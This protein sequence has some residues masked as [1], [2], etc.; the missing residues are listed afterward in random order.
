[1][2]IR[3]V[4][5]INDVC[6]VVLSKPQGITKSEPAGTI[7][8]SG[9]PTSLT[10]SSYASPTLDLDFAK[11]QSVDS[12]ITFSRSTTAS[13]YD[14]NGFLRFAAVNQPRIQFDPDTKECLGLLMENVST[15]II[16]ASEWQFGA[17]NGF[18]NLDPDNTFDPSDVTV[19]TNESGTVRSLI[20]STTAS[21]IRYAL[22]A[23]THIGTEICAFSAFFKQVTNNQVFP[24]LVIDNTVG[25]GVFAR[26]NLVN[27]T[28][29]QAQITGT[30]VLIASGIEKLPGGWSRCWVIGRSPATASGRLAISIVGG[31]STNG[32]DPPWTPTAVGDGVRV[33]GIQYEQ[34][35]PFNR[36]RP[37][38]YIRTQSGAI[39]KF[40]D[41]ASITGTNFS[42]WYNQ[43]QG[44][45]LV[46][47]Y[48]R[49]AGNY[50]E[51]NMIFR[52]SDGTLNNFIDLSGVT[53]TNTIRFQGTTAAGNSTFQTANAQQGF[54][55]AVGTYLFNRGDLVSNGTRTTAVDTLYTPPTALIGV[56]IGHF[57]GSFQL[58]DCI[59]RLVYYPISIDPNV[60]LGM[61]VPRNF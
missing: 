15:N 61:S 60:T 17:S 49:Y 37:S 54:N 57:G 13:Y 40:A 18:T 46:D 4:N 24:C 22:A 48:K 25:S 39:T 55:R 11:T 43:S 21:S 52:F 29:E 32:Y 27:G 59:A 5:Y 51:T 44:T 28:V 2:T 9:T 45:I 33:W 56:D 6:R 12:R 7:R 42:R 53:G 16:N 36:L 14:S 8:I 1:M 26:F 41:S 20:A 38:S 23:K 30:G 31:N 35:L 58:N 50:P 34:G 3:D 19:P 47:F 10:E